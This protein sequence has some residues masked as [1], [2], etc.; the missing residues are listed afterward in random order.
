MTLKVI[1]TDNLK[2]QPL[3]LSEAAIRTL[4]AWVVEAKMEAAERDNR[5][6]NPVDLPLVSESLVPSPAQNTAIIDA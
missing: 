2:G 1:V 3:I 5:E 4:A 6:R